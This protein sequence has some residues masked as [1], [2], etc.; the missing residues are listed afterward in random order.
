[1]KQ[2]EKEGRWINSR[3]L[4]MSEYGLAS[5]YIDLLLRYSNF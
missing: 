4:V 1:M 5:G 2:C 3:L